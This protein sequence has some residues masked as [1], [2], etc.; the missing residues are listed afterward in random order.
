MTSCG[1]GFMVDTEMCDDG[2]N[3]GNGCLTGCTGVAV[4]WDCI[5]T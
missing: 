1:D 3:D 4:G 2:L 5:H